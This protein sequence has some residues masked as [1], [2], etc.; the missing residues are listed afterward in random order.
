MTLLGQCWASLPRGVAGCYAAPEGGGPGD[1][2]DAGQWCVYPASPSGDTAV[3]SRRGERAL[4]QL[5]VTRG[6]SQPLGAT[7]EADGVNFSVYSE[8]ATM[9]EL[10]LFSDHDDAQ[11][12][13]VIELDPQVNKS[14]HFWHC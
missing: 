6:R 8:H 12:T 13:H 14:F 7:V 10:L 5:K 4:R 2:E 11:P 3:R 1:T 9:I